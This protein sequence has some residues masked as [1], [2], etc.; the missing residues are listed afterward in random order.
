MSDWRL[1]LEEPEWALRERFIKV[2]SPLHNQEWCNALDLMLGMIADARDQAI[3]E[4][5]EA[6]RALA[7]CERERDRFR[8]ALMA[9][10]HGCTGVAQ[11][12]A[13]AALDGGAHKAGEAK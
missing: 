7:E 13:N 8:S 4:R 6:R 12:I 11:A 9:I 10:V 3:A 1:K 2:H 5:D